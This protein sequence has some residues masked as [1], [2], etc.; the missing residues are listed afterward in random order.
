MYLFGFNRKGFLYLA[1]ET[2]LISQQTTSDVAN[3]CD[4]YCSIA[5][6]ENFS[7]MGY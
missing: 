2:N 6:F 1:Y 7:S 3:M 4:R 5:E